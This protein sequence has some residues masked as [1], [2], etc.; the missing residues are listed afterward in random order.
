LPLSGVND[1]VH[2]GDQCISAR[3][4]MHLGVPRPAVG[5]RPIARQRCRA[6]EPPSASRPIRVTAAHAEQA[7]RVS[8]HLRPLSALRAHGRSPCEPRDLNRLGGPTAATAMS[9]RH[10]ACGGPFPRLL[11][12]QGCGSRPPEATRPRPGPPLRSGP[13]EQARLGATGER[14]PRRGA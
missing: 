10:V 9:P 12:R 14:L 6:T 3:R 11:M 13:S 8:A 7:A 5:S 4:C 2:R 1:G